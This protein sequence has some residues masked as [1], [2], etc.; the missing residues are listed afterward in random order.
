[1]LARSVMYTADRA[2]EQAIWLVLINLGAGCFGHIQCVISGSAHGHPELAPQ[3]LCHSVVGAGMVLLWL[4]R[5][6]AP[7]R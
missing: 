6:S 2:P 5:H 3:A 1:M 7:H 4:R